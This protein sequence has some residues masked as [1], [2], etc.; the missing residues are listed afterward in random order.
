MNDFFFYLIAFIFLPKIA[1][2]VDFESNK[3]AIMIFASFVFITLLI[4]Y[5]ASKKN[6]SKSNY[7]AAGEK[8]SGFQN[9]LAIAGDY[10]SAASFLGIS[11]LVFFFLDLMA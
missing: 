8:I 3:F 1:M 9:G 10:M 4:T 7:F 2:A 11:G 5:F 6:Y